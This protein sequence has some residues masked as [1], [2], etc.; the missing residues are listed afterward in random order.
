MTSPLCQAM[1][2]RPEEG[3]NLAQDILCALILV[4][5][6]ALTH[7]AEAMTTIMSTMMIAS[8]AQ[9]PS[10]GTRTPRR[11]TTADV[12]IARTKVIPFLPPSLLQGQRKSAPRNR[13]LRQQRI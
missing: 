3:V 10:A 6:L 8:Q 1:A 9:P 13:K 5:G 7:S 4:L 2:I 12:S 11:V